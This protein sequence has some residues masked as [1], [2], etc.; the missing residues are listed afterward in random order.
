MEPSATIKILMRIALISG[1]LMLPSAIASATPETL[2]REAAHASCLID[3][4]KVIK[5]SSA[6]QGTLSKVQFKRGAAVKTGEMVAQLESD[7]EIAQYEAAKLKAESDVIVKSKRAELDLAELKLSQLQQL[8]ATNSTPKQKYEEAQTAALLAKLALDQAVYE[9]RIAELD[10][11]RLAAVIERRQIRSPVDGV[12]TKI[13]LHEGE[14]ADPAIPFGTIAEIRP[15]LVEIYLPVNVYTDVKIGM[16]LT[17]KPRDP[18]GGNYA[19]KIIS[20]DSIIDSASGTF[21]VTASL[22]NED[23]SIPAGIRCDVQF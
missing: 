19:L 5:I 7:V 3:A 10:V 20:K 17:I 18:V 2:V 16:P 13:D 23:G 11:K 22:P 9:K 21:Q 6:T 1:V 14:Y 4:N 8:V 15:L 12:I